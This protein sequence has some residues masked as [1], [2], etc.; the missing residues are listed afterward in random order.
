MVSQLQLAQKVRD[1]FFERNPI[2]ERMNKLKLEYEKVK[3]RE[4]L[5]R[6]CIVDYCASSSLCRGSV[7]TSLA[8]SKLFDFLYLTKLKSRV[9]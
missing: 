9:E 8:V 7:Q 3:L 2:R 4:E 5:L 1:A 6:D